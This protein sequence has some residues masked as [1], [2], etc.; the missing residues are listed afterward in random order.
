[1]VSPLGEGRGE[2]AS[3]LTGQVIRRCL[4]RMAKAWG[5]G[6]FVGHL[7]LVQGGLE[8]GCAFGGFGTPRIR[9]R[10]EGVPGQP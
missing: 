5:S 6:W 10:R 9:A 3:S 1:M 7:G 4:G 2:G 8:Q